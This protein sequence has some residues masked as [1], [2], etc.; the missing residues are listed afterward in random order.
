MLNFNSNVRQGGI[1]PH[2]RVRV[3]VLTSSES[4]GGSGGGDAKT[5]IS[6]NTLLSDMISQ[7]NNDEKYIEQP[8]L[9]ISK[10]ILNMCMYM[11]NYAN[12]TKLLKHD[13]VQ[14]EE[15]FSLILNHYRT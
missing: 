8:T 7:M 15:Y 2:I 4:T 9:Y 10:K 13:N 12:M 1:Y 3:R 11:D 6:P 14:L 5:I